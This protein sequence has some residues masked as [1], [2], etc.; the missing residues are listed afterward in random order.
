M[1]HARLES[2]KTVFEKL[3][4]IQKHELA[5]TSSEEHLDPNELDEIQT[6]REIVS[7]T[8]QPPQIYFTRT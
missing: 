3:A 1:E 6:L 5:S 7:E 8:M 4:E 2:L